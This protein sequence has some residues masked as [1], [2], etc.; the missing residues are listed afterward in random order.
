MNRYLTM[1]YELLFAYQNKLIWIQNLILLLT[2]R[3][4][5]WY[6]LPFQMCFIFNI[7][8]HVL[9]SLVS[10]C[11]IWTLVNVQ[12]PTSAFCAAWSMKVQDHWTTK[13]VS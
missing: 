3:H 13:N 9:M 1:K 2:A 6:S 11:Q 8:P 12:N 7:K 4:T 10:T 5:V